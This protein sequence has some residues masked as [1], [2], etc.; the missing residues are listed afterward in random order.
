MMSRHFSL[1]SLPFSTSQRSVFFLSLCLFILVLGRWADKTKTEKVNLIFFWFHQSKLH[2]LNLNFQRK[3]KSNLS[4]F[5]FYI[6]NLNLFCDRKE[7]PTEQTNTKRIQVKQ[8]RRGTKWQNKIEM[9]LWKIVPSI[10]FCSV[11]FVVAFQHF[12]CFLSFVCVSWVLICQKRSYFS[13]LS[14]W[15]TKYIIST[16]SFAV[17]FC[18]FFFRKLSQLHIRQQLR[19]FISIFFLVHE[20]EWIEKSSR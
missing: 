1:T 2:R 16:V 15:A 3:I 11:L 13:F 4:S 9:L 7:K 14:F 8:R 19:C 5:G 12:C 10:E 20:R 6:K 17:E 18:C